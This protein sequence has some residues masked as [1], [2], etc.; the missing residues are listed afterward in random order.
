MKSA[1]HIKGIRNE[2]KILVTKIGFTLVLN[3]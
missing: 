3:K 2:N 1:Q